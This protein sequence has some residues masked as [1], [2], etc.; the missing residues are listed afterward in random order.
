MSEK[1][2]ALDFSKPADARQFLR[3]FRFSNGSP[4]ELLAFP[5]G[6]TVNVLVADDFAVGHYASVIYTKFFETGEGYLEYTEVH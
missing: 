6:R 2:I 1:D 4:L 3:D 5:N